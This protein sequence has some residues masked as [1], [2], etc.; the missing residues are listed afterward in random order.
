MLSMNT[1]TSRK[2]AGMNTLPCNTDAAVCTDCLPAGAELSGYASV[3][4]EISVC[5]VDTAVC[6]VLAP[7]TQM[8]TETSDTPLKSD[9]MSI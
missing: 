2:S 9:A 7:E 5:S 4:Q 8:S 6:F 3:S 1:R